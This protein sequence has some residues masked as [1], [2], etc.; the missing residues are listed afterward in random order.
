[1]TEVGKALEGEA[2]GSVLRP[3]AEELPGMRGVLEALT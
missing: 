2:L 3:A 1:M